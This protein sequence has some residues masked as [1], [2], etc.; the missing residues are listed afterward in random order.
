MS[1]LHQRK[2]SKPNYLTEYITEDY[3]IEIEEESG[4]DDENWE[5]N[6]ELDNFEDEEDS[7]DEVSILNQ[8]FKF[9]LLLNC[10]IT[11]KK[12]GE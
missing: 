4:S 3:G 6:D 1:F 7:S 9:K 2:R 8:I 12:I 10:F 11:P 5:E